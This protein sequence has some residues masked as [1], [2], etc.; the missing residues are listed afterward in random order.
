MNEAKTL[1]LA[2]KERMAVVRIKEF[3]KECDKAQK[4]PVIS[5]SGGKDSCVVRHLVQ[6]V[7]KGIKLETA[8]ELFNP[9]VA[10][11]LH[12]IPKDEITFFNPVMPFDKI[13]KTIGYPCI[14]KE[15]AQK[16]NNVRNCRI[17]G[18]W[19]KAC[20]GL[21][22]SR[23]ISRK[24]LHFLDKDLVDY[25]ISNKCC[26]LIKGAVKDSKS[27]KFVGTTVGESQLRRTSWLKHGCNFYSKKVWRCRP[28]SLFTEKDVWDYIKKYNVLYSKA[29]GKYGDKW[30]R[31]GC[32]CCGFGLSFEQR[33]SDLGISRSRI[34]LLYDY[35][36]QIYKHYIY[37]LGMWKP[38]CDSGIKLNIDDK[39]YLKRYNMRQKLI[40]EWYDQKNF[41]NNL[42]RILKNIEKQTNQKFT[43]NEFN[44][45]L[46][47]YGVEN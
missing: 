9:E 44:K 34:E 2:Q 18:K 31:T 43:I 4:I 30:R 1:T 26:S 24:Y 46:N 17:I 3:L 23:K 5:F 40:S 35:Y 28:I 32:I 37:D 38:F 13:V 36:P 45:I 12:S 41:K 7:R 20:F 6:Q 39:L 29:Y 27:P 14:S 47:N 11:F 19:V 33:L 10:S 16:V 42:I 8:A 22:S 25:E 21:R 15:I